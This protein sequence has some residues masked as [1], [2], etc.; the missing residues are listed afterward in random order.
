MGSG[1]VN[2]PLVEHHREYGMGGLVV[3]KRKK[4]AIKVKP[5]KSR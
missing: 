3:M 4:K 1:C 5:G 2:K